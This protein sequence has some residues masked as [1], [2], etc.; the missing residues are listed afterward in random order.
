MAKQAVIWTRQSTFNLAQLVSFLVLIQ[1]AAAKGVQFVVILP[2]VIFVHWRCRNYFAEVIRCLASTA[3]TNKSRINSLTVAV[4]PESPHSL[5]DPLRNSSFSFHLL[6]IQS[7]SWP[8]LYVSAQ[9]EVCFFFG[10]LLPHHSA[11]AF[12]LQW[13]S[14]LMCFILCRPQQSLA[15]AIHS[16][17]FFF[18]ES[19][20]FIYFDPDVFIW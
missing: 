6:A 12:C 8:S 9:H 10:E 20:T 11:H 19:V 16:T 14:H 18:F 17:D 7:G 4:L 2:S 5:V 15:S 13:N 3:E 1:A